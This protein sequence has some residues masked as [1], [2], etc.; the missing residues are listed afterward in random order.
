[1]GPKTDSFIRS[2]IIQ[3]KPEHLPK[4]PPKSKQLLRY[5]FT[6]NLLNHLTTAYK[7]I[8]KTTTKNS[9]L[10]PDETKA[11]K[12][13]KKDPNIIIKPA[14]KNLGI[15]VIDKN[16]YY[17][18]AHTQHL[19]D[20]T[21]YKQLDNN[22]LQKTILHI[23]NTLQQ[24][25]NNKH[26]NK[27]TLNKLLAKEKTNPGTFYILPKLHKLTLESRPIISN[28]NH[29][30]YKLSQHVHN[31]LIKTAENAKSHIK[32]SYE[33]TKLLDNITVTKNTYII[34]ADIKSLYTNIPNNH[35]INTVVKEIEKT[36]KNSATLLKTLLELILFNNIFTFNNNHYLQIN[37]TAMGTIM[38][39]TYANCYLKNL[40]ESIFLNPDTNPNLKNILLFK[41]YIDDIIIIYN[42]QDNTL[43]QTL[44]QLHETYQPLEITTKIGQQKIT[45]LD[46]DLTIDYI[47]HKINTQLHI[48]PTSNKNYIPPTSLHPKPMLQN[49]IFNDFLR[50]NRLCNNQTDL[51]KHE[52]TILQKATIA[53]YKKDKIRQL[54]RTARLKHQKQKRLT[55]TTDT[56]TITNTQTDNKKLYLALTYQG[57]QTTQLTA[58]TKHYW[59]NNA[60]KD[61]ELLVSNRTHKNLKKLLVR[62]KN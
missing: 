6:T 43:P 61:T 52:T 10:T 15:C 48:K 60:N 22:P 31:L 21:T 55:N 33:L 12:L 32:N 41:R 29:P 16:L 13:L 53:G 2:L 49:I 62:S 9:N 1:M 44:K 5:S 40:E 17:Q 50:T 36:Q 38:A 19:N 26:I 59:K 24:L 51:L 27:H 42:N 54:Q 8:T 46:T 30:T 35:G 3:N 20:K 37:G 39:P 57:Q 58:K 47:H 56:T 4:A 11:L 7:D 45:Y 23:N 34:T 25:H 28:I 14:D 18:L